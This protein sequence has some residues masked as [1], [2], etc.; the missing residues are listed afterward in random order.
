MIGLLRRLMTGTVAITQRRSTAVGGR[1]LSTNSILEPLYRAVL[2]AG[3][4]SCGSAGTAPPEE[5]H[6]PAVITVTPELQEVDLKATAQISYVATNCITNSFKINSQIQPTSGTLTIILIVADTSLTFSCSGTDGNPQTKQGRITVKRLP[7][8]ITVSPMSP[9]P[10]IAWLVSTFP[11][12]SSTQNTVSCAVDLNP[13][14]TVGAP[15]TVFPEIIGDPCGTFGYAPGSTMPQTWTAALGAYVRVRV[16][17]QGVAGLISSDSFTVLLAARAP[18]FDSI[19]PNPI[20]TGSFTNIHLWVR[21][22][23][24][25]NIPS[26]IAAHFTNGWRGTLVG[27]EPGEGVTNPGQFLSPGHLTGGFGTTGQPG[28]SV[29]LCISTQSSA[30]IGGGSVCKY[31]KI[32]SPTTPAPGMTNALSST[33]ALLGFAGKLTR[34][35][36]PYM[37]SRGGQDYFGPTIIHP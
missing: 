11:I 1:R 22:A 9:P 30:G 33:A 3:L 36:V 18:G 13:N 19:T 29:R 4:L 15:N 24:S 2:G 32:G 34:D 31:L 17:A 7:P 14:T 23:V 8:S 26:G 12:A 20:P 25:T 27:F 37:L 10:Y 28:D 16:T 6:F 35:A 21:D 5:Q